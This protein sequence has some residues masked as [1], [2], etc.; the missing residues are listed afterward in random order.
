MTTL[1]EIAERC[2]AD[3]R[4]HSHYADLY[5]R[6]LGPCRHEVRAVL[7][8]GV[9]QGGSLRMWLEWF[10]DAFV[11]GVDDGAL[12]LPDLAGH[13][14]CRTVRADQA[15]P[16]LADLGKFNVV[17]DDAGHDPDKQ[18]QSLELLWP[19]V[20]RGG[21]YIIEDV[22]TSYWSPRLPG[23]YRHTTSIVEYLKGLLD[24]LNLPY[25]QDNP[26]RA[27]VPRLEGLA[28][29]HWHPNVV[30]LSKG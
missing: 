5:E 12:D 2:R 7:E 20:H 26:E 27:K 4:S 22:E 19:Q 17:I 25:M 24:G 1:A 21:F 10:P 28:E 8:L 18:R 16:K 9:A 6:Y 29:M 30:F 11:T 23:D 14:R 13:P 3:K 15:D